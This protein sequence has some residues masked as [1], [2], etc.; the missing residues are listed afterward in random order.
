MSNT[1][2]SK[3]SSAIIYIKKGSR[4]THVSITTLYHNPTISQFKSELQY[5]KV[6]VKEN[7]FERSHK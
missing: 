3:P 1:I 5:E 7:L 6:K 4:E 2:N